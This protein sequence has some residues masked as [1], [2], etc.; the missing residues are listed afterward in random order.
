MYPKKVLH[1]I[2]GRETAPLSGKF[3]ARQNPATGEVLA[4][5]AQ[6]GKSDI[7][8]A[9]DAA[10][11]TFGSWSLT[12]V[13][14]RANILRKAAQLIGERKEEIARIVSVEGGK[15]VRNALGEA[16]AAME[17]GYFIAGEGRRFYGKTT[18]SAMPN[19]AA[20]TRR[21][22]VGVCGLI[23]A[24]NTPLPNV[25][26]KA[27]PALL[28]G[29]AAITKPSEDTPLS[30][31]W[32]AKTLKEAG[33]PDGVFSVVQGL[34]KEAGA[35]LAQNPQVDLI[36]FTGS[37]AVGKW[38][39]QTAGERLARV[40]LELGGKNPLVVCDDADLESAANF[41]VNSAFSNAGQ[42]CASGSRIIIFDSVYEKFR[43]IFLAKTKALKIG[44]SDE[45]DLGP[46]INERQLQNMLKEL[47]AAKKRGAKII[48]GGNRLSGGK[49]KNGFYLE[50][51]ILENI[52]PED[53]ISQHELFGPIATLYRAKDFNHALE[54]AN[55][56][57]FGLTA[58]IHTKNIHRA[59]VFKQKCR[60]GVISVNGPTHGSEPHLP[61]G[62]IKNSGNGWREPGAEALDVYSEWK[63]IYTRHDPEQ[64]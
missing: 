51:T 32:F 64:A 40:C 13:I 20:E 60:A 61:F 62:G 52:S 31:L 41:A 35:A 2:D 30:A 26:W 25:A 1:W 28:C 39:T 33:L 7:K 17:L 29:N 18:T 59:E 38:I 27:F 36:S 46:V 23:I 57:S 5:V 10:T 42:R 37:V 3:I 43:E 16:E 4:E 21:E 48:A 47:A 54:L 8:K 55:N 63:T 9:V 22:A 34:G 24:S 14:A 45:D 12:P 6:G 58:A 56:S 11:K 44:V 49:Y 15:S 19:R 50:P 53:E